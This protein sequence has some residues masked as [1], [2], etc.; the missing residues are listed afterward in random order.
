MGEINGESETNESMEAIKLTD[1]THDDLI[2]AN[3]DATEAEEITEM[4]EAIE[5]F[6]PADS[7]GKIEEDIQ[8][9]ED[10]EEE[11]EEDEKPKKKKKKPKI[12]K[13]QKIKNL[14]LSL[15]EALKLITEEE[16]KKKRQIRDE[17]IRKL[18]ME[19]KAKKAEASGHN[20]VRQGVLIHI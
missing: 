1:L 19:Q 15:G 4:S 11:E 5:D 7:N 18:A 10:G 17:Q 12:K 6:K 3:E 2:D 8:N 16:R 13:A 20:V 9:E 14:T